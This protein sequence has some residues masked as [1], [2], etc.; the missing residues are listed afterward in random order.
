LPEPLPEHFPKVMMLV[1]LQGSGKTTSAAKLAQRMQKLGG[2]KALLVSLDTY[3]PAAMDQLARL[4]SR[5]GVEVLPTSPDEAVLDIAQRAL[6]HISESCTPQAANDDRAQGDVRGGVR[7]DK[8]RR[9]AIAG[10]RH[11]ILDTAGRVSTDAAMMEELRALKQLV[12]PN[13]I[14]CVVDISIGRTAC[15]IVKEFDAAVGL[16]GIMLTKTDG[17]ASGGSALSMLS[18]TGKPVK[19][20][21]SGEK[22]EDIDIF[23]PQR[24][25][26]RMLGMGDIVSLVERASAGVSEDEVDR[27]GDKI[28]SGRF[29]FDDFAMQLN[30]LRKLGGLA[31][32]LSFLPIGSLSKMASGDDLQKEELGR[33]LAMLSAMTKMERAK[34]ELVLSSDSRKRRIAKGSGV[35]LGDLLQLLERFESIRMAVMQLVGVNLDAMV[36]GD[37]LADFLKKIGK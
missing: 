29:D 5:A 25:A 24:M 12:K 31:G 34:P 16:T 8:V 2:G 11:L 19:Y 7:G 10:V 1:G 30:L 27:V 22:L 32:V 37:G 26:D 33:S 21:G 17:D 3:R 36:K 13:E 15:D 18:V 9:H 6:S 28:K 23:D 20:V 14:I 35:K 4:G